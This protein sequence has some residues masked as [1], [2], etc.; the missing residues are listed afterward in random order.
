MNGRR[1]KMASP[2]ILKKTMDFPEALYSVIAGGKI[3]KLEWGNPEIYLVMN[4]GFLML[5]KADGSLHRLII[6]D[7]DLLGLDWVAV[8]EN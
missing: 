7:G 1:E 5:R 3:T 4:G 2:S 8:M 6:S